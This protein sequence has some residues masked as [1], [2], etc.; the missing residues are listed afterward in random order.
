MHVF[1]EPCHE[2]YHLASPQADSGCRFGKLGRETTSV[3][4]QP[5]RRHAY[6][7]GPTHWNVPEFLI[8]LLSQSSTTSYGFEWNAPIHIYIRAKGSARHRQSHAA[9]LRRARRK[10]LQASIRAR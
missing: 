7:D 1:Y 10:M 4:E 6:T 3:N 8:N 9:T 2:W 5:A